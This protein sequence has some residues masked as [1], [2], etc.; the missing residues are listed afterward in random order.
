M[1]LVCGAFP[2]C[3]GDSD[4]LCSFVISKIC[5]QGG[6]GEMRQ[7]VEMAGEGDVGG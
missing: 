2:K 7:W 4:S 6:V 3:M 1:N 5:Q